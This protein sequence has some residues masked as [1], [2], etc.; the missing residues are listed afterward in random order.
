M[1]NYSVFTGETKMYKKFSLFSLL[2][3][4]ISMSLSA[5]EPYGP[6]TSDKW[7]IWAYSSAAPSFIGDN[8]AIIGS[9]GKVLREGTNGWTCQS[10]NPRPYPENGWKNPHEAM[11]VCHDDEG[12]KWMMAYMQG[13]KP[14]MERDSY[15]WMLNGDMGEDNTKA[16]V[17]NKEDSTP[18]EWIE[19]GPHLMLMPKDPATLEN[20]SND[21][22]SGAPYVMFAGTDYA[23]LMIPMEGYYKYTK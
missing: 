11:A 2:I 20:F 1:N 19:S 17:F 3:I 13:I 10:A 4:S 21:F 8:A 15:M 5:Y 16:G 14:N 22:M 18:G 9:S 12:M 7:Q 23:H 6:H